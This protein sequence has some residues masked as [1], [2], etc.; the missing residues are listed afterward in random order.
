MGRPG[1]AR[2]FAG[3]HPGPPGFVQ[4]R[5]GPPGFVSV[6]FGPPGFIPVRSGSF[7]FVPVHFAYRRLPPFI[8]ADAGLSARIAR[9]PGPQGRSAWQIG[10]FGPVSSASPAGFRQEFAVYGAKPVCRSGEGMPERHTVLCTLTLDCSAGWGGIRNKYST[11]GGFGK[12]A[13]VL[14]FTHSTACATS[15]EYLPILIDF[16][17]LTPIFGSLN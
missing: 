11:F 3:I 10:R 4:V 14:S 12:G 6:R 1:A 13:L 2:R 15:C 7:R 8:A 5:F 16:N 17:S 9:Y